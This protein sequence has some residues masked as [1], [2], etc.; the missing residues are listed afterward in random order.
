MPSIGLGALEPLTDESQVYGTDNERTLFIPRG[1]AWRDIA[2]EC[3]DEGVGVSMFLGM[4]KAIDLGS[5]GMVISTFCL[6]N[7]TRVCTGIVPSITGGELFFHPRYNHARDQIV[8]AS[9]LRRLVTRTT[10]FSCVMRIRCSHG[11]VLCLRL[12]SRFHPVFLRSASIKILWE[13]SRTLTHGP[14]IRCSR[15]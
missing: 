12:T 3:S 9:Q 10:A 6:R 13:F 14:G 4:S 1:Y 15:L 11:N 5:I 8:M 7:L 2:E